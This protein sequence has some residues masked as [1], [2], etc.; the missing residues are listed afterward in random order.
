MSFDKSVLFVCLGNICRS[1]MAEA[2]LRDKVRTRPDANDWKID[3][4]GTGNY[5]IGSQPHKRTLETLNE[6]GIKNFKHH[7]RQLSRSDYTDFKWIFVFDHSNLRDVEDMKPF[8]S[9]SVVSLLR[10]FDPEKESD[11][12]TVADPWFDG[13][14]YFEVCFQQCTRSLENFLEQEI[15]N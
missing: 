3:S 1:P 13:D 11:S 14:Q 7:A 12:P 6:H 8:N 2:I 10:T 4:C 15:P 5:H 9:K